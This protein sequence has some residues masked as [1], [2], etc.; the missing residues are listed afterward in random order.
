MKDVQQTSITAYNEDVRSGKIPTQRQRILEIIKRYGPMTRR[1]IQEK[2]KHIG[3]VNNG[4]SVIEEIPMTSVTGRV[5]CLIDSD[6]IHKCG[7][8]KDRVTGKTV[9]LLAFGPEPKLNGNQY[10]FKI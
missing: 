9:Q 2:T 1:E 8:I 7:T 4:M 10:E 6:L 3:Y 5:R